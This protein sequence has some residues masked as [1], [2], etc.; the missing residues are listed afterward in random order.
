MVRGD[1][2]SKRSS[3]S[4]SDLPPDSTDSRFSRYP[5]MESKFALIYNYWPHIERHISIQLPGHHRQCQRQCPKPPNEQQVDQPCPLPHHHLLL[6]NQDLIEEEQL[7]L[8]VEEVVL[9][10]KEA[11]STGFIAARKFSPVEMRAGR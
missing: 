6:F 10:S 7:V 9:A 5:M 2:R 8:V 4:T 11:T 3:E 1:R